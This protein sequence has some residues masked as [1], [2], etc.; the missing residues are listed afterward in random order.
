MIG[1]GHLLISGILLIICLNLIRQNDAQG[2]EALLFMGKAYLGVGVFNLG[3]R[4]LVQKKEIICVKTIFPSFCWALGM[5]MTYGVFTYFKGRVSVSQVIVAKSLAPFLAFLVVFDNSGRNRDFK[6]IGS[7]L[8]KISILFGIAFLESGENSG[9]LL[10]FFCVI[11]GYLISQTTIR[12]ISRRDFSIQLAST[13]ACLINGLLFY[14]WGCFVSRTINLDY[15]F[16]GN[17]LLISGFILVIQFLTLKGVRLSRTDLSPL[18]ISAV[19]PLTIIF[20]TLFFE[21]KLNLYGISLGLLYLFVFLF[22]LLWENRLR[23]S[24]ES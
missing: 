21:K 6:V 11:G 19:V 20:D 16:Q 7:M 14:V 12:A 15:R 4:K 13:Y 8:L 1:V 22:P 3:L 24:P 17:E 10:P 5:T 23:P 2:I 9:E 18:A